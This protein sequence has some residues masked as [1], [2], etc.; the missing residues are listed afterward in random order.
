[1]NITLLCLAEK[2]VNVITLAAKSFSSHVV[3]L[4]GSENVAEK[5]FSACPLRESA[6]DMR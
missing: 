6:T 1:L 4:G 3:P 2:R 5:N